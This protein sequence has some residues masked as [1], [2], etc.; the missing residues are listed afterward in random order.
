V[1]V[2]TL[3]EK[4]PLTPAEIARRLKKKSASIRSYLYRLAREGVVERL[5]DGRYTLA[6]NGHDERDFLDD[7]DDFGWITGEKKHPGKR[8]AA[9]GDGEEEIEAWREARDQGETRVATR[10]EPTWPVEKLISLIAENMALA[11][12][13]VTGERISTAELNSEV[14]DFAAAE[15]K[16]PPVFP[17]GLTVPAKNAVT[18][19]ARAYSHM[20]ELARAYAAEVRRE[21]RSPEYTKLEQENARLQE[22]NLRLTKQ[23]KALQNEAETYRRRVVEAMREAALEEA[24]LRNRVAKLEAE[25]K[26]LHTDK[27]RQELCVLVE[28]LTAELEKERRARAQATLACWKAERAYNEALAGMFQNGQLEKFLYQ[29]LNSRLAQSLV[30]LLR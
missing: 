12:Y 4:E 5:P 10:D 9:H 16:I 6:N 23:V 28:R 22:E 11:W 13:H 27:S 7:T 14:A 18:I 24:E 17:R 15:C 8:Q 3:L 30:G 2:L 25:L 1:N 21:R 29:E 26:R 19:L 20:A